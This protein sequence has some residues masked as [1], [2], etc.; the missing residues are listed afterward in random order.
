[1]VRGRKKD[2][3]IPPTR[4]LTQQRDYRARKA[5][6]VFELEE[7]CRRAEEENAELRQE[8][9]LART[10]LPNLPSP[11][12]VQASSDLLNQL[13]AAST[14]IAR[15]QQILQPGMALEPPPSPCRRTTSLPSHASTSSLPHPYHGGF[16]PA[17]FPSPAPSPPQTGHSAHQSGSRESTLPCPDHVRER[18]GDYRNASNSPPLAT[19]AS[20]SRSPSLSLGSE[21]CGGLVDC[22][23]LIEEDEEIDELRSRPP[24]P[25]TRTTRLRLSDLSK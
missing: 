1:M 3:T 9:A 23:D 7:R 20:L 10:R 25:I 5:Q 4:A 15:F 8:L 16:R 24:T 19:N 18:I 14:S 6:Y 17:C 2:L 22:T 21:C 12:L 13:A 11:D